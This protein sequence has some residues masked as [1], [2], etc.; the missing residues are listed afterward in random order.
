MSDDENIPMRVN[1]SKSGAKNRKLSIINALIREF[2]ENNDI[3]YSSTLAEYISTPPGA[4]TLAIW[5]KTKG[6][7]IDYWCFE[8]LKV[9]SS[10]T[11]NHLFQT[12]WIGFGID[13]DE[14]C[15]KIVELKLKQK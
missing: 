6:Y 8:P 3:K 15:D 4:K 7:K 11:N 13:I 12:V 9:E 14:S 10:T 1:L 2:C 5:A